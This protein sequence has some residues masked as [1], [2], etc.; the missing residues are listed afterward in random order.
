MSIGSLRHAIVQLR[1]IAFQSKR[2]VNSPEAMVNSYVLAVTAS[3]NMSTPQ[4]SW[5]KL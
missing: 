5:Q 2:F 4:H 3:A 1:F